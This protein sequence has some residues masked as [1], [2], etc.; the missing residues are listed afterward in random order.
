MCVYGFIHERYL[1]WMR[2]VIRR[3]VSSVAFY[4]AKR[5]QHQGQGQLYSTGRSSK[6]QL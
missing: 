1:Q 3:C 6:M 2:G 4:Q 5:L